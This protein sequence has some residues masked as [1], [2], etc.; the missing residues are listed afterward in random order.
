MAH[1]QISVRVDAATKAAAEKVF[2]QLGLSATEAVRMF[3]HQVVMQRGL[4]FEVRVPNALTRKVLK[5][6]DEGKNLQSFDNLQDLFDSWK[7]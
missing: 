4:P 7:D 6:V 1:E 3:Y 2:Q 5:E